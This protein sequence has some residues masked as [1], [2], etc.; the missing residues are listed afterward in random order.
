MVIEQA[1][2]FGLAALHQL[3][4]RVGRGKNQSYCFLIYSQNLTENGKARLK[5]LY[6]NTD[7]FI[8]AEKDMKLR[9]PGE[10]AGI[11]QSGYLTLGLADPIRDIELLLIT[12]TEV[13]ENF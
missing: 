4:G 6:E 10:V 5:A 13:I 7:G 3:R 11:Q 1:E 2:R 9:G 12:R 8:I